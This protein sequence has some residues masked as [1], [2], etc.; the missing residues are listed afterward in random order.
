MDWLCVRRHFYPMSSYVQITNYKT[1]KPKSIK[2]RRTRTMN[3][4]EMI[5]AMSEET[6]INRSDTGDFLDAFVKVTQ[7]ELLSTGKLQ[8]FGLG[9]FSV[10][11]RA[12]RMSRNPQ[13]GEPVKVAEKKAVKFKCSAELKRAVNE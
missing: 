4:P 10:V 9:T 13:T 2:K 7:T 6:G 12:A 8:V 1:K 5:A 3:K 11:T